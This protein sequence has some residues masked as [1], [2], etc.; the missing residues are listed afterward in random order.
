MDDNNFCK[1]CKSLLKTS[2][3]TENN[4]YINKCYKCQKNYEL[5]DSIIEFTKVKND[6]SSYINYILAAKYDETYPQEFKTCTKCNNDKMCYFTKD[7]LK[8][9]YICQKCGFII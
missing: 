3:D 5:N 7:N 4:K 1:L 6:N 8:K 9:V 2:F